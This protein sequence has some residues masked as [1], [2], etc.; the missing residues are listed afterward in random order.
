MLVYLHNTLIV[1]C[2]DSGELEI[3]LAIYLA[4]YVGYCIPSKMGHLV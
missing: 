3:G 2:L 1:K 4:P